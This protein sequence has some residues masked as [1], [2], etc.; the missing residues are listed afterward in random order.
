VKN[1]REY[2]RQCFEEEKPKFVRVLKAVPPDKAEYKPHP[3]STSAGD[4]VW[5]LATKLRDACELVDHGQV[6]F[7]P[8][9]AP[10]VAQYSF[11]A[12]S[13]RWARRSR[14]STGRPAT[15]PV[16]NAENAEVAET[17]ETSVQPPMIKWESPNSCQR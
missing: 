2:Y 14:P 3:R 6:E 12:I 17:A 11:P 5:L 13:G 8:R 10:P 15:T 9:P 1:V 7:A 4:L 16:P